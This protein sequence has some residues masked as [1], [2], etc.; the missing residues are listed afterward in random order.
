MRI[1]CKGLQVNGMNHAIEIMEVD[2][3]IEKQTENTKPK[4]YES[5]INSNEWHEC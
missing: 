5:L 2:D 1:N 4:S 3:K